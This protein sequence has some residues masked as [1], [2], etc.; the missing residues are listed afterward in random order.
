[1]E[2]VQQDSV[3]YFKCGVCQAANYVSEDK[4]HRNS[5]TNVYF[6][7]RVCRCENK[8]KVERAVK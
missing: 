3:I 1:M 7:C 2:T 4:R 5:T 6:R 8:V